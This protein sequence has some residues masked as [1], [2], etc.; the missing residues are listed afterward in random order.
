MTPWRLAAGLLAAAAYALLSHWLTVQ[1]AGQAWALP[2]VLA[3]FW[4]AALVVAWRRRQAWQAAAL[5][6]AVVAVAWVVQRGGLGDMNRLYLLQHAGIHLALF[7]AFASSLRAG[8]TP[9]IGG[10]AARVH[11]HALTP[12]MAAYSRRVTAV[13]A[14]YFLAM[15]LV[16]VGV[17]QRCSIEVWSLLANLATPLLIAALFVGEYLLRYRLHPEFERAS[18]IDAARAW[19][20]GATP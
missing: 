6:L 12:A 8:R 18:L 15:A 2:A 10:I 19:Q 13:W 17:Y 4:L 5:L 9:L 1:S 14:G 16:S 3:P 11:G 7:A 20:R